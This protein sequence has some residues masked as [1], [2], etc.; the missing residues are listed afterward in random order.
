MNLNIMAKIFCCC[1]IFLIRLYQILISPWIGSYCKYN[2]SCSKY[3]IQKIQ[4]YQLYGFYLGIKRLITC[5]PW[6]KN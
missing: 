5:H 3:T 1:T 6:M 2:I 4:K